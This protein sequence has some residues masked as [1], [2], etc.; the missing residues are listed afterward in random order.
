M[1][2]TG[3]VGAAEKRMRL[4][5]EGLTKLFGT[6]RAVD[7]LSFELGEGEIWGF[8]GPNGSGK[9]TTLRMLATVEEPT[10][11]DAWLNGYSVIKNADKVRPLIGFMP[12]FFGAYPDM[13]VSEYLEF[14]A[15]A[16]GLKGKERRRR[17]SQIV[18]FMEIGSLLSKKVTALSRGMQQRIS[19]SRALV[20]DPEL[21][22]LDEPAAGLDPQARRDL[23]E[24]L[25]LLARE[26]KTVFISSH[27]LAELEGLIDKVI[28]INEGR[29]VYSGLPGGHQDEAR[30]FALSLRVMGDLK[31]CT[32]L[33]LETPSVLDVHTAEPD[34][35]RVRM[36]GSK[37][38]IGAVV[39]R[40]VAQGQIPYEVK[41]DEKALEETYLKVTGKK[42][43]GSVN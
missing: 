28:I 42:N 36:T 13:L 39:Q 21:L 38:Q 9:T 16:Y 19:I 2:R 37:A 41:T 31:Q 29:L 6:L 18:E 40:L 4:K 30:E 10:A 11:G 22:L 34:R 26:N 33:L 5:A 8:I 1:F 23:R 32:R 14:F 35:L 20:H 15:R 43:D 7:G 27:I 3:T 25:R 17:L 24:L 12:D